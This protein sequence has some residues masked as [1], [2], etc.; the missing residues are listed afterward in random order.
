MTKNKRSLRKF[1]FSPVDNSIRSAMSVRTLKI[2]EASFCYSSVP[3][4]VL[5][6][7]I[8]MSSMLEQ[9]KKT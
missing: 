2:E 5:A 1:T 8:P 9:H 4:A 6:T 7:K 3:K